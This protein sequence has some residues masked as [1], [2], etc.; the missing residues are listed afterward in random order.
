MILHAKN[1]DD[2]YSGIAIRTPDTNVV[3]LDETL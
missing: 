3:A 1:A 2:W